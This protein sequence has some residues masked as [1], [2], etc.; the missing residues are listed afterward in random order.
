MGNC[1]CS[2]G[3]EIKALLVEIRDMKEEINVLREEVAD[4]KHGTERMDKHI[5]MIEYTMNL[6]GNPL[7]FFYNKK[8]H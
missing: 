4:I 3:T 6:L 1:N 2:L 5:S 8:D 7:R